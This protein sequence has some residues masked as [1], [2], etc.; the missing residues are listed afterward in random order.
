MEPQTLIEAVRFYSD[1]QVCISTIAELRWPNGPVCPACSGRGHYYLKTQRRWKCKACYK[2]FSVKVGTIFE[3]SA[4][5]LDKWLVSLWTIVNCKNGIS[6]YEVARAVGTTQK[7]AW[8]MLHRLRLALR[9]G[10]FTKVAGEVE[11]DETYIGGSF[12]NMHQRKRK[13]YTNRGGVTG[14]TA[15]VGILKR[16]GKVRATVVP[17]TQ[18]KVIQAYVKA[19]VEPGAELMTDQASMYYGLDSEYAHQVINHVEGYV[20]GKV[21]TNG[22]ENFWSLLKRGL[23][24]TYISVQ[25]FHLD[26]YVDE[27]VFRYN[28]RKGINDAGRFKLALSQVAGKRLT[29][30]ELTG[31]D[32]KATV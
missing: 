8:F 5:S 3:D 22:I 28:N 18:T 15:V 2:Q 25:P 11:A 27:Q 20:E 24:G 29:H 21:H 7:S 16:G 14:K 23:N 1:E 13:L 26:R 4:L 6:S 10:S 19:C 30:K 31:K 17:N 12:R 9:Q 32:E